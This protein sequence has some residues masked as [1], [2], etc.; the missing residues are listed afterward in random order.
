MT[1]AND[2]GSRASGSDDARIGGALPDWVVQELPPAYADIARQ[3]QAL[4]E[5]AAAFEGVAGVL[6][7]DGPP[8]VSALAELFGALEFGTE[9]MG[10]G[11]GYD[12]RVDLEGN[13]RLLLIV[14]G[15]DEQLDRRSPQLA[16]IL[17]VLQEDAGERDRV[18]LAANLF[19][20]MPVASRPQ[21]QVAIEAMRLIQGLGA[22]F[23]PTS[24][25]FGIWKASLQDRAQAKRSVMNLHAMDG[26][27]FR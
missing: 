20:R 19:A 11:A 23:V 10:G 14:V 5:Q 27:I 3:I 26:G 7:Q 1:T 2:R 9:A 8:L 25:L 24:A 12:L 4:R 18:V 17:R 15:G 6:W 16:K 21:D 22:N 13:R